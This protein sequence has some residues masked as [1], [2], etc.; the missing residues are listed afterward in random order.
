MKAT[1]NW[2][3]ALTFSGKTDSGF[4]QTLDG[5]GEALSP[6]ETV[7]LAVGACSSIDVVD[8]LKKRRLSITD[9]VCEL[10]ATRADEPP[11]VFT[12]IHAHYRV[13]GDNLSDKDVA[14]AVSLS[15][16]KYCSVMLMLKGNVDISTSYSINS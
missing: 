2:Q 8:I 3:Q 16:E 9:C 4:E 13:S 6:M 11:R 7:L 14:R 1:V 5:N 10:E 12:S 15:A